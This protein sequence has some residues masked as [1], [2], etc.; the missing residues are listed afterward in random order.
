[1][2]CGRPG[3][4]FGLKAEAAAA[5]TIERGMT[6]RGKWRL[7]LAAAF[8]ALLAVSGVF[9]S[10]QLTGPGVIRVTARQVRETRID[11]GKPGWNAGD[12]LTVTSLVYNQRITPKP[13][14]RFEFVCTS[15]GHGSKSCSATLF[16]PKGKI[17]VTGVI[18]S[19][20]LY[21]VAVIGGTG[22]YDNVRGT[23]TVTSLGDRPPRELLYFRLVV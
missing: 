15:L 10:P 22:L 2:T 23:L 5:E 9:A 11:G 16:M 4:Q 13:I 3:P 8:A 12:L 21:E 6:M 19:R 18:R 20:L 1:M 14:G 17:M 7:L